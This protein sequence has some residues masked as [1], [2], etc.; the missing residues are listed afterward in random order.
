[1]LQSKLFAKT[2][3]DAPKEAEA[4]SHKLLLQAGFIEQCTAGVYSFLPLGFRVLQ[5]LKNIIRN[6]I[7]SIDGQE[8][9]LPSIQPK[10]LWQETGRWATI[11]PPLFK[12]Q[13][14]HKKELCLGPTHEEVIVDIARKS[15]L[16]HKNLPFALYQIQNKFRNEMRAV[17]GLLR[18]REFIMKDLYSFHAS[19]E[20]LNKYYDK[21]LE[22]YHELFEEC[23]LKVILTEASS[24]TIGGKESHEFMALCEQGEDKILVCQKCNWAINQELV[25]RSSESG[26]CQLCQGKLQEYNAIEIGHCFK[27]GTKYSKKMAANFVDKNGKQKPIIMGCYGIGLGRLMATIIETHYDKNGIIWPKSVAPFD[28]HLIAL[29]NAEKIYKKLSKK[30]DVLY[31]DRDESPGVK[32]ADADLIG[33]PIRIVVSEKTL[34]QDSV[35]IK[36]RDQEKIKLEKLDKIIGIC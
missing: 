28:I 5:K 27:L 20:C 1:M 15:T 11:D 12:F 19:Q 17:G 7:N 21:V 34:K 23:G 32:F 10:N 14:R 22:A 24:G 9:F 36:K 6:K 8:V 18:V 31:D 33:I 16:S 26:A 35:E 30:F 13:D 25:V 3:R 4:V 2:L 29:T